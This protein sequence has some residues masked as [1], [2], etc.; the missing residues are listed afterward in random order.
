M[1][2]QEL[3]IKIGKVHIS[4]SVIFFDNIVENYIFKKTSK[5]G[6]L[7]DIKENKDAEG[8]A[9]FFYFV[10]VKFIN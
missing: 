4:F 2:R 8:L 10:Q 1:G 6:S 3:E 7:I 9:V 5:I